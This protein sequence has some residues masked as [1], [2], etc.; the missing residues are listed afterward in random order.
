M[1][2]G[3][4]NVTDATFEQEVI[5]SSKPVLVDFWATWCGPCLRLTPIVEE[6]AK[7]NAGKA[8][9][10][11]LDVDENQGTAG[12]YGVMSIPTLILFK[13]GKEVDRVVG[14]L[15]KSELQKLIDRHA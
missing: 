9:V 7:E 15:P 14:A 6:L 5:K 13:G 1:A 2:E 3:V 4:L 8:S 10:A 11:K 12:E